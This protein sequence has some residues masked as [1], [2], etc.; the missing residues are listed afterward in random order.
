MENAGYRRTGDDQL[1]HGLPAPMSAG[2]RIGTL[3]AAGPKASE[4]SGG[5][6]PA[7][8]SA[9]S[10]SRDMADGEMRTYWRYKPK[11]DACPKCRAM[12]G[13]WFES[14]PGPVHPNCQCEIEEFQALKVTGRSDAIIVP[15]GV[16]I[17]ANIAE[18]RQVARECEEKARSMV[19]L[20]GHSLVPGEAVAQKV[21]DLVTL[22]YKCGWILDNFRSGARYDFKRGGHPEYEDFGNYHYGLY[23]H[24]MGIEMTLAQV[25]AGYWQLKNRTSSPEFKDTYYDDPR[26]NLRIRQGQRYPV[27]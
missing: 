26:D 17:Q 5:D 7:G 1:I 22:L 12:K 3:R 27:K 9:G 19:P 6:A 18:A 25:A 11:P 16:D 15:P 24:A 20:Y 8:E 2:A 21:L 4:A 10:A 14:K 23:T 13:L